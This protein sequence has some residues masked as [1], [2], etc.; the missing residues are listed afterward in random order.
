M[1]IT[2][3]IFAILGALNLIVAFIAIVSG[4]TDA[5]VQKLSGGLLV[6]FIGLM[7][8][9]FANK[10]QKDKGEYDKWKNGEQ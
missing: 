4:A 3:Y 8:I 6:G 1:K 7:L 2:G 10:K 9:H 5:F